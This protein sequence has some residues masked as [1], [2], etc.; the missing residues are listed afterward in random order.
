[1]TGGRLSGWDVEDLAAALIRTRLDGWRVVEAHARTNH[2]LVGDRVETER[3]HDFLL[4][5]FDLLAFGPE[6]CLRVQVFRG[7][8]VSEKMV[9]ASGPTPPYCEDELWQ[10]VDGGFKRWWQT[11]DEGEWEAKG[12]IRVAD[13]RA[14][15]RRADTSLDHGVTP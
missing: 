15:L 13:P 8:Q 3:K 4:G 12:P 14:V 5:R 6:S 2:R 7:E 10:W 1:M 11:A 9:Q